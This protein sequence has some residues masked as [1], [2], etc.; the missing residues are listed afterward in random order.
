[1]S[2]VKTIR[3]REI[4][5][6]RG[7]PTVETI[8]VLEDGAT[9][10]VSVPSG[11]SLGK[12]EAVELRDGDPSRFGGL[13]VLKATANVNQVIGARLVGLESNDQGKI[14]SLMVDLDGT[15]DKSKLGANSILSVS[16]AIACAAANSNKIPLY[17]YLNGLFL[18]ERTTEGSSFGG[19]LPTS[20][21]KMPTPTFNIINGGKHGAGNLDFQ[22]FH[23]I[24]A[25]IKPYREALQIGEEIYQKL[26]QVLIYRNAIHSVGDEGGFA[27]NLFTNLDA[28]EAIQ[29]AI[30]A[31]PY[32]FGRDVFLGLDVAATHFKK[33]DHYQIKDRPIPLTSIEFAEYLQ[34]LNNQY[35][36]LILEDPLDEDDWEGW[37]QLTLALGEEALIVGDDL[38]AT[39]VTR[40]NQAINQKACNAIL[41]KPNQVG[42]LTETFEV[43]KVAR[44]GGFKIIISHRS[45]ETNDTF[46]A[47]LAVAVAAEY[48]KFGA[49]A[50]GER[51]AKY[52]R[53]LQ[54]ETELGL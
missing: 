6:S 10:T 54:I 49:P 20:I 37:K 27:P 45:G 31:T 28:L 11:A 9:G 8:A 16:L 15:K 12:Y 39:N 22:E 30:K 4:L 1:M 41:V 21:E 3:A 18:K 40:L 2:K 42:T 51:V 34:D 5:D 47:D 43:I 29:E 26:K 14:D 44:Q 53:L 50:R 19:I 24:P 46:I 36:L 33:G 23:V 17:R 13:G 32:V 52:N 25:T 7:N 35:R 38:L 48:V